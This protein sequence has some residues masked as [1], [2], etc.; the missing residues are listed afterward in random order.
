MGPP[1]PSYLTATHYVLGRG[2]G[3]HRGDAHPTPFGH[4]SS[5]AVAND[6]IEY[7]AVAQK[8]SRIEETQSVAGRRL[9]RCQFPAGTTWPLALQSTNTKRAAG[10]KYSPLS[11]VS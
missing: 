3:A 10:R 9:A 7:R 5:V 6:L 4:S 2:R 1:T 11:S 8:E